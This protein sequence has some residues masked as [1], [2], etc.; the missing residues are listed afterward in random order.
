[1]I[2]IALTI[3]GTCLLLGLVLVSPKTENGWTVLLWRLGVL[4]MLLGIAGSV[5]ATM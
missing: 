3:V 2:A 1:M 4:I 5:A